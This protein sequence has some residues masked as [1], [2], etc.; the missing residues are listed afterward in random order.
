MPSKEPPVVG[1]HALNSNPSTSEQE[2][3][4]SVRGFVV[5]PKDSIADGIG[6]SISV[7]SR[8]HFEFDFKS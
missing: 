6:G 7:L 4:A 2:H 1:P 5:S 3:L 8:V